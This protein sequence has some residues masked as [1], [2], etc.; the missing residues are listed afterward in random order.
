MRYFRSA[1]FKRA[2]GSLD[3]TR[4]KRI[5]RALRQLSTL[6]EQSQRPFGIGLKSLKPNVWEIRAGLGDRILF[7]WT[8]EVVEFLFVGNHDEIRRFLKQL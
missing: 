3:S 8:G 4:Q 2:Y 5:D 7:H 1:A 6:Y